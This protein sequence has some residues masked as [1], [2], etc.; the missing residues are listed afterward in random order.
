MLEPIALIVAFIGALP[1]ASPAAALSTP[2]S[3]R[4]AICS[5]RAPAPPGDDFALVA[6]PG[7]HDVNETGVVLLVNCTDRVIVRLNDPHRSYRHMRER[8]YDPN[9]EVRVPGDPNR[10]AALNFNQEVHQSSFEHTAFA[11]SQG[12]TGLCTY[13][14]L[15]LFTTGG[16]G[17][18]DSYSITFG[19]NVCKNQILALVPAA[20]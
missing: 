8:L 6:L 1:F 7:P 12:W 10:Y 13:D 18:K 19:I 5:L 20:R 16:H 4:D 15:E 3:L 2:A 14:G 9:R 11:S 17:P